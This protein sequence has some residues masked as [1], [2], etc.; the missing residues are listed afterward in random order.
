MQ[1]PF[2]IRTDMNPLVGCVRVV[3]AIGFAFTGLCPFAGEQNGTAYKSRNQQQQMSLHWSSSLCR[4]SA[5]GARL[6]EQP[7]A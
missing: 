5:S 2:Q 7:G 3:I 4:H 1:T 6:P